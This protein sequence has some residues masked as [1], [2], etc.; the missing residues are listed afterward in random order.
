MRLIPGHCVRKEQAQ[1][2][3][4]LSVYFKMIVVDGQEMAKSES[5]V[6]RGMCI[7]ILCLGVHVWVHIYI[8]IYMHIPIYMM[9]QVVGGAGRA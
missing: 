2:R 7:Y 6:L 5:K 3:T 1:S 9:K 4:E 8:Y